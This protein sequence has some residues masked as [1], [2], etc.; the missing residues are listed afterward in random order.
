MTKITYSTNWMGVVNKDWYK[1]RGLTRRVTKVLQEDSELT[2]RKKGD[3]FEYDEITEEYSCGRIDVR[4]TGMPYGDE[5]GVDPMRSEDW[6]TFGEWLSTVET[7]KM[8]TLKQLVEM[9]EITN[10]KIRWW[11][12]E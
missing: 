2:G 12:E 11:E 8:L 5:I 3:S 9:Y 10:T 4:G 1:N 7:D 6:Y